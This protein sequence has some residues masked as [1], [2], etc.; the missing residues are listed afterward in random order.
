MFF[1]FNLF[2]V[3]SRTAKPMVTACKYTF[4]VLHPL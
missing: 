4:H 1:F 3:A 2:K